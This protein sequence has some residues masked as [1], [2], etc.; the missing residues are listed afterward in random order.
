MY[1]R[2]VVTAHIGVQKKRRHGDAHE[3]KR[4]IHTQRQ[5]GMHI[6]IYY[7]LFVFSS[8]SAYYKDSVCV[9]MHVCMYVLISLCPEHM[10]M[11]DVK[12]ACPS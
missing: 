5:R 4:R 10:Y 3:P 11:K 6:Y 2:A 1:E 9:C 7:I 12:V 8:S